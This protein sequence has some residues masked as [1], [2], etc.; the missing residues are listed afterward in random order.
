MPVGKVK[1]TIEEFGG[2]GAPIVGT[3]SGTVWPEDENPTDF[4]ADFSL[5][6]S[7]DL[8]TP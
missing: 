3:M 2:V 4:K 8:D 1:L 5:C 7:P 6:R